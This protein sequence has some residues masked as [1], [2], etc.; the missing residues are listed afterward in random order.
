V[1]LENFY[2][3]N[4]V[5]F[6]IFLTLCGFNKIAICKTNTNTNT[7]PIFLMPGISS[8]HVLKAWI[9]GIKN[10]RDFSRVSYPNNTFDE[11]LKRMNQ[12]PVK[13]IKELNKKYHE[14]YKINKSW[15]LKLA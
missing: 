5:P 10:F 11:K 12:E 4:K 8:R 6:D 14:I 2:S 9:L 15:N 1:Y 3:I 13:K 7:S